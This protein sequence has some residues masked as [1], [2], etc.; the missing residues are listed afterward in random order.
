[1]D[2]CQ[3]G[4]DRI[5]AIAA[6]EVAGIKNAIG[7]QQH[8]WDQVRVAIMHGLGECF[9]KYGVARELVEIDL[10]EVESLEPITPGSNKICRFWNRCG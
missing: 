1:M 8:T 5:G 4:K 3:R 9:A 7:R 2:I 10:R 6:A